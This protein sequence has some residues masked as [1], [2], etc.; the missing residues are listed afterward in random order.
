MTVEV[1]FHSM[2]DTTWLPHSVRRMIICEVRLSASEW[3]VLGYSHNPLC[4]CLKVA[5]LRGIVPFR[6]RMK[7]RSFTSKTENSSYLL[8]KVWDRFV[9]E[10]LCRVD[11]RKQRPQ[12]RQP[13]KYQV[14]CALASIYYE[15]FYTN[16][17]PV[18]GEEMFR[19]V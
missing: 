1:P 6:S 5:K 18:T 9:E 16:Y 19:L 8:P 11:R 2:F 10:L 7:T 12:L 17:V 14:D 4:D 15:I 13:T 3:T